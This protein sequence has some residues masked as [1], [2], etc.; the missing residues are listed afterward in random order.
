MP[1]DLHDILAPLIAKELEHFQSKTLDA[2]EQQLSLAWVGIFTNTFDVLRHHHHRDGVKKANPTVTSKREVSLTGE[3]SGEA[4][5]K[6]SLLSDAKAKLRAKAKGNKDDTSSSSS[7]SSS[8][9]DEEDAAKRKAKEDEDAYGARGRPFYRPDA[10]PDV[11][12]EQ[13]EE[14][15]KLDLS[16]ILD[17]LTHVIEWDP[18]LPFKPM[19]DVSKEEE[20]E[21]HVVSKLAWSKRDP[22]A[23]AQSVVPGLKEQVSIFTSLLLLCDT[24]ADADHQ[25]GE[26]LSTLHTPIASQFVTLALYELKY[27]LRQHVRAR[28]VLREEVGLGHSALEDF[29]KK[30]HIHHEH[31]TEASRAIDE[32]EEKHEVEKEAAAPAGEEKHKLVE[33]EAAD[34]LGEATL[35]DVA[36]ASPDADADESKDSADAGQVARGVQIH[37]HGLAVLLS[38]K[39]SDGLTAIRAATRAR[40]RRILTLLEKKLFE[41]LPGECRSPT[42]SCHRTDAE[43]YSRRVDTA[44]SGT[45]IRRQSFPEPR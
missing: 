7:S 29:K 17:D 43:L 18:L 38:T 23:G 40:F 15:L 36:A 32:K 21:Q 27:F 6:R 35:A 2:L 42:A 3:R 16:V 30:L 22:K 10:D 34:A 26:L 24:L 44:S 41:L 14:E 20:E 33:R 1:T 8:S 37:H 39:L 25:I 13:L 4:E 19:P 31:K 11:N 45:S 9:S 5:A 28:E 12:S